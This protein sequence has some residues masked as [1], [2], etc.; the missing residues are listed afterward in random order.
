MRRWSSL[1]TN[2]ERSLS[3]SINPNLAPVVSFRWSEA[4]TTQR[5]VV[6]A[7]SLGWMLDAFDVMLYSIV[8]ATLMRAFGMSR[9]TAGLLNALTLIASA[10]GGLLFGVLADRF[11]R[12]RMLSVSILVYSVFTFACG[13]STSITML[14]VCRFLLGLGMGGEW[15]T[16]AALV[17]ESW[18]S[19]LRGRALGI[20]QSS[21]AVGYAISAVVAGLILAH[22]SWRW[23]FF[24]GILPAGLVFWIQSHV[25]EPP[26]W[27]RAHAARAKDETCSRLRGSVKALA[28]LTAT[29][30]LGMF[31]W[32]GLFTWIPAYLVL[33]AAQGGRGFA[34]LSLTG[35]LVTVNLLG[36]LPGYLLFGVLAD[37]FGRKRTFV[38]Y[39]AAA[40]L[41]V[42]LLAGA[43]QPG[44]ILLFA[45]VAA[46]FG[47]GF[48][49]GSGIIGSEIFPTESR[50]TALGIS[51]NVARGLSAL[52]PVTIG[53]LSERHG[54]PW[55]FGA[56]AAAF[57]G[58]ACV[59]LMLPETR[60]VELA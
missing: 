31:G 11:G 13:F 24:A 26:L 33:P 39:L 41:A 55:A 40:A 29:N 57:A 38:V 14:A 45:C 60:G 27:K 30:T 16:G 22:A 36:M 49:T 50:A 21:W 46:F 35:F 9:T 51:Y 59:A 3:I 47:T 15:N 54:L 7:A 37:R 43:R 23:V 18:S 53:V 2:A 6:L 4:T 5:R 44:W 1:G 34:A 20:V 12:R 32:W 58:A 56:S 19:A 8:L 10:L 48:F 17:A 42:P 28:V 25:P 52:A